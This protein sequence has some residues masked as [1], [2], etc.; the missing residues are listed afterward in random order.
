MRGQWYTPVIYSCG[1][2]VGVRG[3]VGW[4]GD[5]G[6]ARTGSFAQTRIL[7]DEEAEMVDGTVIQW[8]G[9]KVHSS[10]SRR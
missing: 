1:G 4:P 9:Q 2:G 3:A 7:R 6:I 8:T 5:G 10:F